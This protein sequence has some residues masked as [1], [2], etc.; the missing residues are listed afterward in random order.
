MRDALCLAAGDRDLVQLSALL[1]CEE[2]DTGSP[3]WIRG[4]RTGMFPWTPEQVASASAVASPSNDGATS[5]S[6]A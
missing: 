4:A 2:G 3:R 6:A 1:V 5:C